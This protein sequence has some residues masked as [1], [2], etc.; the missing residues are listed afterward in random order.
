[1]DVLASLVSRTLSLGLPR[2]AAHLYL[3]GQITTFASHDRALA[4]ILGN[5]CF[6]RRDDRAPHQIPL[7][8]FGGGAGAGD[9]RGGGLRTP[10]RGRGGATENGV[11]GEEW[12]RG[13]GSFLAAHAVSASCP[14]EVK[15]DVLYVA[16]EL[17]DCCTVACMTTAPR[18]KM[19]G[20]AEGWGCR[21]C[22]RPTCEQ[23]VVL[24]RLLL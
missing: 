24:A 7:P 12:L 19:R 3:I 10:G 14:D 16:M 22:V 17:L 15:S 2:A 6:G 11:E 20:A 4:A 5:A 13:F 23:Q 18:V 9:G 21:P 1:M 8:P